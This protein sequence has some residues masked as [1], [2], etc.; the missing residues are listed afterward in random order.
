M[1]REKKFFTSKN[2]AILGILSAF[3]VVLQVFGSYIAI[4]TVRLSFVLVPIVLG[5]IMTG[6]WGGAFLGLIFGVITLIMGVVG[7][8]GFTFILFSD[9]PFLTVAT[10]LATPPS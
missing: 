10:C 5:G 9:H 4:G 7:L 8:D 3:I 6:V 1:E 2:L